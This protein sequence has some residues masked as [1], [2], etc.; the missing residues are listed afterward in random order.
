MSNRPE[1]VPSTPPL[2]QE[3][4]TEVFDT[5]NNPL[6][7]SV[8]FLNQA[9]HPETPIN[10]FTFAHLFPALIMASCDEAVVSRIQS[11]I[12]PRQRAGYDRAISS[13]VNTLKM[14]GYYPPTLSDL[15]KAVAENEIAITL[16]V[17]FLTHL[18][19]DQTDPC[20]T[21]ADGSQLEITPV[22]ESTRQADQTPTRDSLFA[23]PNPDAVEIKEH[24]GPFYSQCFSMW[25][26]I[27][28]DGK[29]TC[30]QCG[31]HGVVRQDTTN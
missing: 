25:A 18:T 9:F 21:L 19:G 13:V 27:K 8:A 28:S 7:L 20:I 3:G 31:N 17:K 4:L 30:V 24:L 1:A 11:S 2:S 5:S 26:E 22:S 29:L 14:S 12:T 10:V 16:G 6:Y 23:Q 15:R